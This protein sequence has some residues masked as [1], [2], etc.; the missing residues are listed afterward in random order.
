MKE[1]ILGLLSIGMV[2]SYI[3]VGMYCGLNLWF[4][5]TVI[6]FWIKLSFAFYFIAVCV[7][8]FCGTDW[9]VNMNYMKVPTWQALGWG[10]MHVSLPL[11]SYCLNMYVCQQSSI[12]KC[13]TIREKIL[14][15]LK[16][17]SLQGYVGAN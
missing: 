17:E 11:S 6:N 16:A 9:I 8:L 1:I 2:T 10:V 12:I 3:T 7:M 5:Y 14:R 4:N 15:D 13:D